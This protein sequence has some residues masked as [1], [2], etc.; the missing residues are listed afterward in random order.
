M[1]T[2]PLTLTIDSLSYG[3]A[4]IGRIDGKVIFVPGTVPGDVVEVVLEQDKKTY[5]IGRLVA[6]KQPSPQRREPP[7]PYVARCGGCPWQQV[8]YAEQLRV[9][10]ALVRENMRRIG[11]MDEPPVRPIL[12]SP[13]EWHYR[14][15]IRLRTDPPARLGFYLAR[16]H[17]LV[18]IES[19][20]IAREDSAEQLR[21]ARAWLAV[22]QTTVRR[23]ELLTSPLLPEHTEHAEQTEHTRPTAETGSRIVLVGNAE[24]RFNPHDQAA[25][26]RFLHDHP[27]VAGLVLFGKGWRHTWGD[28]Q[29]TLDLGTEGLGTDKL[30]L[31]VSSGTF[32]QVNAAGNRLLLKTLLEAGGFQAQHRVIE[33]YCGAGNLSLPLARRVQT[34]TGIEQDRL[35]IADARANAN[36]LGL[37]NAQF[38]HA[39]VRKGL[40]ALLQSGGQSD[41]IADVIVLDPPRAGA[42]DIIDLLPRLGAQRIVYVSCDP[43]TLA[44]DLRRLSSHHYRVEILQPIDLFPQTYHVETIAVAVLTW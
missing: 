26:E 14:H 17:E 25:C 11:G 24:G 31:I 16:T 30:D 33:L 8:D 43:S 5:A 44:R 20:L 41:G 35:S 15:R 22:L 34:L 19:C 39:S 6:V 37:T 3:P 40:E 13:Q 28:T 2:Q 27:V 1:H 38:L 7:C 18:E 42:A 36:R 4:G 10:E 32:T 9:K 12:P 29:L 21:Q 23:V